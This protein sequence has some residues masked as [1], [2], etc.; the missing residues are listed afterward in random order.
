[1]AETFTLEVSH[2]VFYSN[3]KPVPI[4]EIASSLLA[5]E[6]ILHRMPRILGAV[7][8]VQIDG[9]E[10]FVDEIHSGSLIEDMVIKLIFKDQAGLDAFLL[11]INETLGQNKVGRNLLISAIIAGVVGYGLYG[12]YKV[13][14]PADPAPAVTVSNNVIIN[15]GAGAANMP[16][17]QLAKIIETAITDKKANAKDAIEF[18][19]PAKSDASAT[20]TFDGHTDLRIP[21]A[22]IAETPSTLHLDPVPEDRVVPDVD[23][24][25]R[26]TNLDN[27]ASGWAAII[28]GLVDRR[29][30]LVLADDVDPKLVAH[31][32]SV[33]ADVIVH[34]RPQG[35]KKV[36]TPYQ[37]TITQ[38][39][40]D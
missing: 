24:Q 19:K 8:D 1:M 34:S 17:E 37:I 33:R 11:K 4:A 6:R 13:F 7:T 25:I 29:V 20:I 30:K 40:T 22:V 26:A 2:R 10:V 12:A 16:P 35:A 5:L 14:N 32:Y 27:N 3:E 9:L 31:R 39:I 28:P 21:Q 18:I 36:M 15:I 38:V 23:L